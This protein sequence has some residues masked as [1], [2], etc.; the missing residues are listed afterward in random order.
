MASI[1]TNVIV[2]FNGNVTWLSTVIFKSSCSIL[3]KYFPFDEQ[4]CDMIFASWTFGKIIYRN[5]FSNLVLIIY[6][7]TRWLFFGYIFE[8]K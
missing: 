6:F 8:Y 5:H 2:Q 1:S 3:V 7:L 4:I